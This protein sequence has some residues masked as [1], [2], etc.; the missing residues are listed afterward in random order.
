MSLAPQ[1]AGPVGRA[2]GLRHRFPRACSPSRSPPDP[3][4]AP[5]GGPA[6]G[7][8]GACSRSGRSPTSIALHRVAGGLLRPVAEFPSLFPDPVRVVAVPEPLPR[9]YAVAGVRVADGIHGLM[10]LIDPAFD[11]RREIVLPE[12]RKAEAPPGFRGRVLVVREAADRV[13]LEAEL[14]AD[15]YVVLVDGHDP[16]WRASVDGR[17]SPLL[18]AN[19]AFRAVAVSA[20][21]H[22]GGD[23]LSPDRRSRGPRRVRDHARGARRLLRRAPRRR[24]STR[25]SR[26]GGRAARGD[27]RRHEHFVRGGLRGPDLADHDAGRAVGEG[28]R[29]GQAWPPRPGRGP[30]SRSRCRRRRSR[31]RPRAR[32]RARA[33]AR[34]PARRGSCRARPASRAPP[35]SRGATRM[36]RPA[37]TRLPRARAAAARW[38]ARSRAGSGSRRVTP[39]YSR[40]WRTFGSTSTGHAPPPGQGQD[41]PQ[42]RGGHDALLVVGDHQRLAGGELPADRLDERRLRPRAGGRSRPRGRPAPPAGCGRRCGS[43]PWWAGRAPSSTRRDSTPAAAEGLAH[44]RAAGVPAHHARPGRSAPPSERTFAAT[45][46]APPRW[47]LWPVTWTTGTGASGEMRRHLAPDE[48]VEH[49]VAQHEHAPAA[50]RRGGA[51]RR[52]A[53]ERGPTG[54]RPRPRARGPRERHRGEEEARASGPRSRRDCIRR[55]PP[56]R[57]RRGRRARPPRASPRRGPPRRRAGPRAARPRARP[58]AHHSKKARPGS[59]RSAAI[60]RTLLWRWGC[61]GCG[62]SGHR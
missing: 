18:R 21:I 26:G 23:G 39:R 60:C 56:R 12:G 16:G 50:H 62:A 3:A 24:S 33:A 32:R 11:P 13:Q 8:C 46:P 53:R 5:R 47:K 9:A 10:A 19:V 6:R 59:P 42:E 2:A 52:A 30:G 44:P 31:R 38:P 51:R 40:K 1:T 45:L 25:T 35:G 28:R 48:L 36:R 34:A 58:S 43:S 4:R 41:A 29:L 54:L 15:G 55:A 57:P 22:H 49:H 7:A 14:S 20:G 17:P 37:A 27:A 61:I